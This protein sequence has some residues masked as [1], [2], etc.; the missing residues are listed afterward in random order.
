MSKTVL[1]TKL[2]PPLIITEEYERKC[3]LMEEIIDNQR[4]SNKY[5]RLKETIPSSEAWW[6]FAVGAFVVADILLSSIWIYE[7]GYYLKRWFRSKPEKITHSEIVKEL[8][9][10]RATIPHTLDMNRYKQL[11]VPAVVG[12]NTDLVSMC[13]ALNKAFVIL[14]KIAEDSVIELGEFVNRLIGDKEYREEDRYDNMIQ[15]PLFNRTLDATKSALKNTLSRSNTKDHAKI[16]DLIKRYSDLD[17]VA[18]RLI[19]M[20]KYYNT[21]DIEALSKDVNNIGIKIRVIE[22]LTSGVNRSGLPELDSYVE[23][24]EGFQIANN[25][26]KQMTELIKVNAE[27][28]SLVSSMCHMY[29]NACITV[30]AMI[31]KANDPES[32]EWSLVIQEQPE[33]KKKQ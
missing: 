14:G 26:G 5:P 2:Y 8:I 24:A 22:V 25:K 11:S 3:K 29:N 31:K 7:G 27:L 16:G 9:D 21:S 10:S 17:Y 13:E 23:K 19:G 20:S 6:A 30:I 15:L 4:N 12:L 18:E 32:D 33:K 28:V 1:K